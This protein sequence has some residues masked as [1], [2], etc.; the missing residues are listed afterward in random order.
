MSRN[1]SLA[2]APNITL[3]VRRVIRDVARQLPEFSHIRASHLLVV[4][5][6]ARRRS[7]ATIRPLHFA[8][9]QER[10]SSTGRR[11]KPDIR[12]R[13]KRILYVITLRPMFFRSS[14]PE[15]RVHTILHELFH[16]SKRFDGTLH[17]ER[18]HQRSGKHFDRRLEPL[19]KRYLD[20][21]P[22]EYLEVL[23][24]HGVALARQW[25]ERPTHSYRTGASN[26]TRRF[27][28][29]RFYDER[30]MFLGPVMMITRRR[31]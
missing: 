18:R 23:S 16:I 1:P 14:T 8:T 5:G 2:G 6:E 31:G 12:F 4:A 27:K 28:G 25:L 22:A 26:G 11:R 30:Q 10:R 17:S 24:H 3:T 21:I 13:G 15:Q 19:V 20:R 29:R 9:T 7:H